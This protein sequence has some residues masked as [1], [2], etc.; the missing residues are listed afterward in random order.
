MNNGTFTIQSPTIIRYADYQHAHLSWTLRTLL[1]RKGDCMVSCFY[2]DTEEGVTI[3]KHM[4][5]LISPH[6]RMCT[7]EV[8]YLPTSRFITKMLKHIISNREEEELC[9]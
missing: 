8:G 7:F 9:Q 2:K 5:W 6:T 1:D 4:L 3:S